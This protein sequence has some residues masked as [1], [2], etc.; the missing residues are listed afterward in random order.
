MKILVTGSSGTIGTHLCTV[1]MEQGHAVIG[2]DK[3]PN[4]WS[5]AIQAVTIVSDLCEE[6]ALA[7]IDPTGID[8]VIHLAANARVHELVLD[9]ARALDN[10]TM[11]FRT[12][13]WVRIN[14]IPGF[15]FASSRECYG[16]ITVDRY[17]E[18]LVRLENCESAYTASKVAG[19]ALVHAYRKCYGIASVILRFSNVYGAYDVS[20]RVIPRFIAG[21]QKNEQLVIY[22]KEKCL[23]FTHLDDAVNGIVLAVTQLQKHNGGTFNIAYGE[24]TTLVELA[25]AICR[26]TGSTS[27]VTTKPS[28]TG[29]IFRYIADLTRAKT[30]LG[31]EPTVAFKEGIE[32]TVQWYKENPCL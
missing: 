28:R 23:D 17:T 9:P 13:E 7:A 32:R 11:L 5:P 19:E 14:T 24:G 18:D 22:G 4:R 16:N 21:A 6:N 30:L 29:E 1:L 8:A 25:Q 31:Y 10:M 27:G 3:A 2:I 20:D 26:L 15:L 12:L